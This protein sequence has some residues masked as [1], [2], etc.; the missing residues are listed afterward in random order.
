MCFPLSYQPIKGIEYQIDSV[1]GAPLQNK[2]TYRTNSEET[3]ELQRQVDELMN[4]GYVRESLSLV[5]T[6][7]FR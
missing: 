4:K 6:Y 3:K 7:W 2:P 1:P 5:L